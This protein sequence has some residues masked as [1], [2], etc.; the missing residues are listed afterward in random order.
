M[1]IGPTGRMLN[2]GEGFFSDIYLFFPSLSIGITNN[3]TLSGGVSLFPLD[4]F[5]D[6]VFYV[7]PKVGISTG[8]AFSIAATGLVMSVPDEEELVGVAMGVATLGTGDQSLT[9]GLGY[10]FQGS[11][12]ADKP[13]VI[14]GGELRMARRLS[15]VSENWILP[16][17]DPALISYGLRFFGE[18]I[19]V[20]LAFIN[21]TNEDFFFPGIP[22]VGFVW[23]FSS[24]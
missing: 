15:F 4:D 6:N 11:E 20:D 22:F 1:Y 21:V 5:S 10:G 7:A 19:A 23:N 24:E 2:A 17:V 18:G 13:A 9:L 3:I 14:A 8:E 12:W 16:G